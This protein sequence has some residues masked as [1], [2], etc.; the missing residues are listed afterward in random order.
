MDNQ[1]KSILT[2]FDLKK[3]FL[4]A[5]QNFKKHYKLINDLNVFPVPDG[6]TG[7]NMLHTLD[8]VVKAINELKEPTVSD[9]A[10]T[11]A[12]SA[13]LGARGNSGVILSQL[14]RGLG[15]GLGGKETVTTTQMGKAFQYGVLFAYRAVT[16]P[17]EGT[18]LTVAKGIAKGAYKVTRNNGTFEEVI[19][20]ALENGEKE[21]AKTP[22]LLPELKAAG[23]VDAGGKGL[24]VFIEGCL[25]ALRGEEIDMSVMPVMQQ[26]PKDFVGEAV[27]LEFP[28]CTEFIVKEAKVKEKEVRKTLIDKG[29]SL[30]VAVADGI[31]KVHV[32]SKNP[33]E[34]LQEAAKWGSLH[35]IKI[36]NMADQHKETIFLDEDVKPEKKAVVRKG[37]QVISVAAGDGIANVMHSIGADEIIYGGQSMNPSVE[38]FVDIIEKG[39]AEKYIIL[40]NN[41][42]IILAAQQ[43]RKLIG[44]L[45]VDY[46]PTRNLAQGIAALTKLD[47][48]RGLEENLTNMREAAENAQSAS[49]S[50]AV[51]DSIVNG[52]E[53]KKGQYLGLREEKIIASGDDMLEVVKDTVAKF[54]D[55]ELISLYY[56]S[57]ITK[58]ETEK[59]VEELEELND[60][61]EVE[62]FDGG[63]P[64]YPLLMVIE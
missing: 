44:E 29:N 5:Y 17:V 62:V 54:E 15:R 39:T 24:I 40:P 50:V 43:V 49:L 26:K 48:T 38:D 31:V 57:D 16:K 13:V 22:E 32:H 12:K 28:Y 61:I 51:R 42:N 63:Q 64:L 18:I 33:G 11:A 21:L 55:A 46:I 9:V 27:D 23:V 10:L 36:D 7:T 59:V 53:I 1:K 4:G 52:I 41:K 14:F 60:E 47:H 6:D 35:D 58:E 3:M 20:A 45:V 25:F 19:A 34:V 8:A 56:G 30:I 37:L 2:G